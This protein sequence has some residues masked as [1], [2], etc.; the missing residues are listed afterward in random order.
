LIAWNEGELFVSLGIGH[1]IWYPPNYEGP[2]QESFPDLLTWLKKHGASFPDWLHESSDCPW[3]TRE[4][5]QQNQ[6]SRHMADLQAL[7]RSTIPQ[8]AQFLVRRLRLA[9]PKMLES[10]AIEEQRKHIH[11]QFVRVAA[12][13]EGLYALIDYVN[14]KG[15]GTSLTERYQG[16]GWGLLQVLGQM[17]PDA[18]NAVHAFADA[19]EQILIRRV[20]NAPPDRQESRWLAGWKNRIHTYR[21]F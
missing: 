13:P 6:Q 18:Q 5:F 20:Q 7:L 4:E 8:Q 16:Q 11:V 3:T 14:F 1:F 17:D 10:V 21:Q 12:S 15:E 19:A 9:L 2:F